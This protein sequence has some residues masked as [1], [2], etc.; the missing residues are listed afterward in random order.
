MATEVASLFATISLN[1]QMTRGL[2]NARDGLSGFQTRVNQ[3]GRNLQNLGGQITRFTAPLAAGLGGA[4]VMAGRFDQTMTNTGSLIGATRAEIEEM[5]AAVLE[6]GRNSRLGPDAAA[7]AFYSI[8]SG[9]QDATTHMD[10]LNAAIGTA[11][12]GNGN[13][14]TVTDG[15]ISVM[16]SYGLAADDAGRVS[17][18]MTRTVQRGVG[19]MDEFAAAISPLTGIAAGLGVDY[20][21]LGSS[22]AYMTSQGFTANES[23]TAMRQA[24]VAFIRPNAD[25]E[26]A[27]S[28][29]GFESGEAAIEALGLQGAIAALSEAVGGS[30]GEM[31][32]ALGS[33][34]AL[35][36]GMTLS[37]EAAAEFAREFMAGMDG[38]TESARA[39]QNESVGAQ[40][41][42]LTSQLQAA[43]I[44]IGTA[45]LPVLNDL[46]PIITDIVSDVG[47][48]IK[49]NPEL[50]ET[51]AKVGL[52][53]LAAG[54][55]ISVLGGAMNFATSKAGLLAGK[56]G[57]VAGAAW[58]GGEAIKWADEKTGGEGGLAS[59][60]SKAGKSARDLAGIFVVSLVGGAA[61]LSEKLIEL[62]N[63]AIKNIPGMTTVF[64][65]LEGVVGGILGTIE[66][67]IWTLL[68]IPQSVENVKNAL[69]GSGGNTEIVSPTLSAQG[70]S[71][72]NTAVYTGG[73]AGVR[74][75]G[76]PATLGN[77]PQGSVPITQVVDSLFGARAMGGPV[78]AGNPYIVGE[79]GPELF[80][81]GSSG[82]IVP[83]H[84]MGGD[85]YNVTIHANDEAGGRAAARGF[86]QE[87]MMRRR[88]RG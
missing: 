74:I 16:N 29:M 23:M 32:S 27:L 17:D 52:A 63:T 33:V 42:M 28:T 20:A 70:M 10:V 31:A 40:F 36:A 62:K 49:D 8:V 58:L 22:M 4:A 81:P 45:L 83:N 5:S 37:G 7:E 47:D 78:T 6:V 60:L 9:V 86:Q 18:L 34:E 30:Q 72:A 56:L 87:L 59:G 73:R 66:G 84:A 67:M 57:L 82:Q 71:G 80:V 77:G 79:Q 39:I 54:P 15:L 53:A 21:E 19:T 13:L 2:Q 88:M 43:A 48:W 55:F 25:M 85:T 76:V 41:E 11:E 65:V 64:Q 35:N 1:D 50:T 51:I 38:A 46:L 14:T 26:A 69:F 12:A 61:K 24:M 75:T 3:T 44:E 68:N